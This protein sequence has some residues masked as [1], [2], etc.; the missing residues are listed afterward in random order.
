MGNCLQPQAVGGDAGTAVNKST[1]REAIFFPDPAMPCRNYANGQPCTRKNCTYA[2]T[3]TSLVKVLNHIKRAKTSLDICVF[4]ITC[5]EISDTVIAAHKRNVQVRVITDDAQSSTKGSDIQRMIQSGVPVRFDN[6]PA[7]MHNKF[8]V[9]DK[10][11]L[12]TGSFNWTRAA[13]TDNRENVI[14][15]DDPLLVG[16]FMGEFNRL[17]GEFINNTTAA[18]G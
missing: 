10:N 16:A 7:H 12:L 11:L 14:A 3:E 13:V 2:H 18:A 9:I 1:F 17:W 8:A 4:T 5:D 6:T 15:T